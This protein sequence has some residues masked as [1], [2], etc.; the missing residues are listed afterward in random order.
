MKKLLGAF[1][2]VMICAGLLFFA[3][4]RQASACSCALQ[5]LSEAVSSADYIFIGTII[6]RQDMPPDA[7]G[8]MSSANP[9]YFEVAVERT[10]KGTPLSH[11]TV[12]TARNNSS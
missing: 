9:V 1:L 3:A 5:D 4:A 2:K 12:V 11:A 8:I 6:A 7:S 10:L